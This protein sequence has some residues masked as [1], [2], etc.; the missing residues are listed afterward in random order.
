MTIPKKSVVPR[1]RETAT[2]AWPHHPPAWAGGYG[3][4]NLPGVDD[5]IFNYLIPGL[6]ESSEVSVVNLAL[7]RFKLL[8]VKSLVEIEA[9]SDTQC[10]ERMTEPED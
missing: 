8:D 3:L 4:R 10:S 1:T 2:V 7:L 5:K 9:D 6:L